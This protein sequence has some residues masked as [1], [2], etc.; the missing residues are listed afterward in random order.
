MT[1]VGKVQPALIPLKANNDYHRLANRGMKYESETTEIYHLRLTN[2]RRYTARRV[3]IIT[4]TSVVTL[5][6]SCVGVAT[7]RCV[8]KGRLD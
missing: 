8:H 1:N 6:P 7:N 2:Q 4:V 5:S 3:C